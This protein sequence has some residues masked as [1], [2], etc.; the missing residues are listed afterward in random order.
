MRAFRVLKPEKK[1]LMKIKVNDANLK[2]SLSLRM[3]NIT[4]VKVTG[5]MAL[6]FYKAMS[7]IQETYGICLRCLFLLVFSINFL[8]LFTVVPIFCFSH[9]TKFNMIE[10]DKVNSHNLLVI[11]IEAL[12]PFF[13]RLIE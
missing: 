3:A 5:K 11:L 10:V 9:R 8:N 7:I 2:V 4:F 6:I 12:K 13:E 1:H